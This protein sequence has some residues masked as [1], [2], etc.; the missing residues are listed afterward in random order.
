M[1]MVGAASLAMGSTVF[2][3]M[4]PS[5]NGTD[6][7]GIYDMDTVHHAMLVVSQ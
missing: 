6:F 3:G 7:D 4:G 5:L 2:A 1:T